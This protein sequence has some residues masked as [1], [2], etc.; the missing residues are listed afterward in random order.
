M[1]A[2]SAAI[3]LVSSFHHDICAAITNPANNPSTS[4]STQVYPVYQ[5]GSTVDSDQVY[6]HTTPSTSTNVNQT[7]PAYQR[8]TSVESDQMYYNTTP[9]NSNSIQVNPYQNSRSVESD[10]IY[11]N[12]APSTSNNPRI[13]P[14]NQRN[15]AIDSDQM[16]YNTSPST[17]TNPKVIPTYQKDRAVDSDHMYYHTTPSNSVNP[18]Q[19]YPVRSTDRSAPAQY[20][21]YQKNT[22]IPSNSTQAKPIQGDRDSVVVLVSNDG[23]ISTFNSALLSVNLS[24]ILDRPGPYTIFAPNNDAFKKLSPETLANLLKPEN[25][26]KLKEIL[27]N[28]VVPGKLIA[29]DVKE[30]TLY[31]LDGKPV[32]IKMLG[33]DVTVNGAKI[34]KT[35]IIGSNGVIHIIDT[36]LVPARS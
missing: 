1:L 5:R 24:D 20:N 21:P 18:K 8:S 17:S 9:S 6:Y 27:K 22:N 28:H 33:R 12:T 7:Y 2:G 36:V 10:Q 19:A 11:Y 14:A 31:S 16:Y 23:S 26:E 15:R 3:F 13:I 34:I 29:A 25:K 30:T 35:D 4:N 32:V